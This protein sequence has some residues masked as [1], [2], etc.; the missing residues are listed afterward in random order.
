MHRFRASCSEPWR[1]VAPIDMRRAYLRLY[2]FARHLFTG[3]AH[4]VVDIA[5]WKPPQKIRDVDRLSTL[6]MPENQIWI[7]SG[8][9]VF[10]PMVLPSACPLA[11]SSFV[12]RRGMHSFGKKIRFLWLQSLICTYKLHLIS[13]NGLWGHNRNPIKFVNHWRTQLLCCKVMPPKKKLRYQ[14]AWE[15]CVEAQS[16]LQM[17]SILKY[18]AMQEL[19]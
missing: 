6:L 18:E 5:A 16:T 4:G 1:Q 3:I 15:R 9:F 13:R 12:S 19:P 10:I 14:N 11:V 7:A 8:K 2:D 17:P